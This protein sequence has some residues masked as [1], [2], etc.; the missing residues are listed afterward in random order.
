[1]DKNSWLVII[2]IALL[3][4]IG[5]VGLYAYNQDIQS[6]F[7][8]INCFAVIIA[9]TINLISTVRGQATK[10][11]ENTFNFIK[12][13]DDSLMTQARMYTRELLEQSTAKADD[14]IM[15]DLNNDKE[16]K[17]S[18]VSVFNFFQAMYMS[19]DSGVVNEDI[20]KRGFSSS[21]CRYFDAFRV[22]RE[23]CTKYEDI[24]GY[25][26]L[27]ALYHRWSRYS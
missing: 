20:L 25:K 18:V 11:L 2:I 17:R 7:L 14:E 22:W 13:W 19:I 23:S 12:R 24:A 6:L 4:S 5:A 1:M 3:W 26:D 21:Y 8:S 15:A 27:H 10:R 16:L 9:T